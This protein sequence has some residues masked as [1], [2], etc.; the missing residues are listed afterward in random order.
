MTW[1]R[2]CQV[3]KEQPLG[4]K[5]FQWENGNITVVECICDKELCNEKTDFTTST[6]KPTTTEGKHS[7]I[8]LSFQTLYGILFFICLNFEFMCTFSNI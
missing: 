5:E 2:G 1:S 6:K 4:C 8:F 3:R 7:R